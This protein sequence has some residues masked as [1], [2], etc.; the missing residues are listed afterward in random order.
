VRPVR[1]S[2]WST[3]AIP[4]LVV[5]VTGVVEP[6]VGGISAP[7]DETSNRCSTA[8]GSQLFHGAYF[9][10]AFRL[11]EAPNRAALLRTKSGGRWS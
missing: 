1:R 7:D 5:T 4:A 6:S 11:I 8:C 9:P 2:N 3:V 10:F